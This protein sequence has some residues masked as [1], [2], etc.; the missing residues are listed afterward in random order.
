[1]AEL[2]TKVQE[3]TAIVYEH[4]RFENVIHETTRNNFCKSITESIPAYIT[5]DITFKPVLEL[6]KLNYYD[7]GMIATHPNNVKVLTLLNDCPTVRKSFQIKKSYSCKKM[8]LGTREYT[9]PLL[10]GNIGETIECEELENWIRPDIVKAN[11]KAM[12]Y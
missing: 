7:N 10:N 12:K 9:F 3:S 1:M 2:K 8:K 6:V 11:L 5:S 4:L